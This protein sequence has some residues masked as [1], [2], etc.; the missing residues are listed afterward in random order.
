MG[1]Q[2]ETTIHDIARQLNIA[3]STV[4]R[5]LNN[6]PIVS[7]ATRRLIERTAQEMGYGPTLWR[8]I[9]EQNVQILLG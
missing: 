2:T 9:S 5:A 8:P 4:S 7:E 3:A 1:K 6:N